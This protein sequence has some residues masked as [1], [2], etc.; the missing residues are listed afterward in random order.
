MHI[1]FAS[2]ELTPLARVGGLGEAA[3]G[4]VRALR[5]A[6]TSVT[7]VVPDYSG[8][9]LVDETVVE[10]DVPDW[11]APARARFGLAEGFGPVTLVR[12]SE[13]ERCHP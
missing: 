3:A 10:L 1:L 11:A 7:V 12:T 4:L 9:P 6:G 5:S 13:I 8:C 2:A